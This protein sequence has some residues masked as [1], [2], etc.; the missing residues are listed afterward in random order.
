MPVRCSENELARIPKPPGQSCE[1]YTT[2]FIRQA[3][4][5][6]QEVGN[7]C[8]F[9]QYSDGDEFVSLLSIIT[10]IVTPVF[11]YTKDVSFRRETLI[12]IIGITG[13]ILVF[14]GLS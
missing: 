11:I 1:N 8:R 5:Y 4:G 7:E 10:I 6:V 13:E 9:C 3:G 2:A 12:S 14:S